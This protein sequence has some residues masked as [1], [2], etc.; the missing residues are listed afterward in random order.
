MQQKLFD[1]F[2]AFDTNKD[3]KLSK[4]EVKQIYLT[5]FKELDPNEHIERI[6]K[7]ADLD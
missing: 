5:L 1:T 2:S 3:G 6:F 7:I 4:E